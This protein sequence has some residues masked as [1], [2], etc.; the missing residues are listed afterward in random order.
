MP[1]NANV[2]FEASPKLGTLLKDA[3]TLGP[4]A[5]NIHFI[6]VRAT[7]YQPRGT[8]FKILL[9]D[10]CSGQVLVCDWRN[11]SYSVTNLSKLRLVIV[12]S[13]VWIDVVRLGL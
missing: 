2:D 12:R 10:W 1:P 11:V 8:S 9:S 4:G 5:G 3:G 7:P 6:D 13:W